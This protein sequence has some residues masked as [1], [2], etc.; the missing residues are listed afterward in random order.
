MVRTLN[1]IEA[2]VW[3]LASLAAVWALFVTFFEDFPA[4]PDSLRW[5][6]ALLLMSSSLVT[7]AVLRVARDRALLLP[8]SVNLSLACTLTTLRVLLVVPW[9]FA[10][11]VAV[12]GFSA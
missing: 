10:L 12:A 4:R 9:S 1:T 2:A 6:S 7:M 8:P 3:L 11:V 5:E